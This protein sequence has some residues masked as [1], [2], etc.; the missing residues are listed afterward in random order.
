MLNGSIRIVA[1]VGRGHDVRDQGAGTDRLGPPLFWSPGLPVA[2]IGMM[3]RPTCPDGL[4]V[5]LRRRVGSSVPSAVIVSLGLAVTDRFD[6]HAACRS[7][8]HVDRGD[9]ELIKKWRERRI[10]NDTTPNRIGW[11]RAAVLG[12]NDGIVS[13]A[14]LIVGVAAATRRPQR[15]PGGRRR[16]SGG[17][18]DVDGGGRV[19]LGQLAVGHRAT[20]TWPRANGVGD[21]ARARGAG[22]GVDLRR[23][24]LTPEL[25]TQVARQ[26]MAHDALGAHARDEL[27][28]SEAVSAR[29]RASGSDLRR[30]VRR[31][32]GLP[33]LTAMIAPSRQSCHWLPERRWCSS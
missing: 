26:L 21:T 17:G 25:A 23:E 33:L 29:P 18:R 20:P 5:H 13:T 28:I 11:L 9:S 32:G 1:F 7:G 22:T 3:R 14:S 30:H 31:R 15:D 24:R 19:C 10:P 12:A 2:L 6:A 4:E 16:G 27:G 8:L